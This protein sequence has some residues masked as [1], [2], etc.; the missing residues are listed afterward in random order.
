MRRRGV[1]KAATNL[2]NHAAIDHIG[3]K[4]KLN[5]DGTCAHQL[6][7]PNLNKTYCTLPGRI[8][9]GMHHLMTGGRV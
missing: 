2:D 4:Q 3:E 6:M 1:F 7:T 5:S 8:D 9:V